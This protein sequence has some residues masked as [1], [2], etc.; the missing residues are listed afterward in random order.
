MGGG[1]GRGG[2][3]DMGGFGGGRGVPLAPR[4]GAP[5]DGGSPPGGFSRAAPAMS[6]LGP[7]RELELLKT[8]LREEVRMRKAA[9]E[10]LKTGGGGGDTARELEVLKKDLDL[11]IKKRKEA[12]GK[13]LQAGPT[14]E[15][16]EMKLLQT[17]RKIESQ[18]KELVKVKEELKT[19]KEEAAAAKAAAAETAGNTASSEEVAKLKEHI[20]ALEEQ[21]KMALEENSRLEEVELEMERKIKTEQ[22]KIKAAKDEVQQHIKLAEEKDEELKEMRAKVIEHDPLSMPHIVKGHWVT[23]Q[24]PDL[25]HYYWNILTNQTLLINPYNP[26]LAKEHEGKTYWFNTLSLETSWD[27]PEQTD[28]EPPL[29][30]NPTLSMNFV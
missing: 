1:F 14:N 27:K 29:L 17:L 16:L 12:E 19:A 10:K 7:A 30:E 5:P 9:E 25:N 13:L 26:W 2:P 3:P 23:V 11:E 28:E 20:E 4:R 21:H 18:A 8:Q 24:T 6:I 22:E 15:D